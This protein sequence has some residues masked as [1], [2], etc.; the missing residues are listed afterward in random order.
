M[1]EVSV[2]SDIM[3]L[4]KCCAKKVKSMSYIFFFSKLHSYSLIRNK[5]QK[6]P[7]TEKM[8]ALSQSS[9]P[10]KMRKD[11]GWPMDWKR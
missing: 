1:I 4:L 2:T 10:S 3:G 5:Y 7:T 6:N 11:G 8:V 9:R